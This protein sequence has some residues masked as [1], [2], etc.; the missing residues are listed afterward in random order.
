MPFNPSIPPSQLIAPPNQQASLSSSTFNDLI[1][2][3]APSAAPS[4]PLQYQNTSSPAN[5][6]ASLSPPGGLP[7][8]LAID[9]SPAFRS[10]SLPAPASYG[11]QLTP[12]GGTPGNSSTFN[13]FFQQH[14]QQQQ[15]MQYQP[16]PYNS[17]T[18]TISPI[19]GPSPFNPFSQQFQQQVASPPPDFGQNQGMGGM[20][21]VAPQPQMFSMTPN[22]FQANQSPTPFGMANGVQPYQQTPSPSFT[23]LQQQQQQVQSPPQMQMPWQQQQQ[24]PQGSSQLS[25][26]AQ[27]AQQLFKSMAGVNDGSGRNPFA[28]S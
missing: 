14:Q 15:Q 18:P 1:S 8:S 13:P 11:Q 27:Q 4:L 22:G 12:M 25:Q 17:I 5:P 9:R 24:Q 23:T 3:Q 19:T 21:P 7:S 20:S 2:I 6:Y 16:Q 28:Y 10:A 26:Q